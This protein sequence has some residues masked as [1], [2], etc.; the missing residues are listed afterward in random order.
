MA[1]DSKKRSEQLDELMREMKSRRPTD[2]EAPFGVQLAKDEYK[3]IGDKGFARTTIDE[4]EIAE[5][6]AKKKLNDLMSTLELNIDK[7]AK[8][9]RVNDGPPSW[10]DSDGDKSSARA[11]KKAHAASAPKHAETS[12]AKHDVKP[13]HSSGDVRPQVQSGDGRGKVNVHTEKTAK[14][15]EK[16]NN[17]PHAAIEYVELKKA[18]SARSNSAG[19]IETDPFADSFAETFGTFQ[20][21]VTPT[22]TANKQHPTQS[23]KMAKSETDYPTGIVTEERVPDVAGCEST[24]QRPEQTQGMSREVELSDTEELD[25]NRRSI[26]QTLQM[27]KRMSEQDDDPINKDMLAPSIERGVT[28]DFEPPGETEQQARNDDMGAPFAD[29]PDISR[30]YAAKHPLFSETGSIEKVIPDEKKRARQNAETAQTRVLPNSFGSLDSSAKKAEKKGVLN[31]RENVDDNFREFFGDTVIIDREALGE[32]AGRQRKIKDFVLSDGK[33]GVG[34]PVFEDED[35][36]PGEVDYRTDEDTEL[37]LKELL[38]ARARLTLRVAVTGVFAALLCMLGA[39]AEFRLLPTALAAPTVF[40]LFNLILLTGC[41]LCNVKEI[42]IGIT[43]LVTLKAAGTELVSFGVIASLVEGAVLLATFKGDYV[44]G[45]SAFV[46]GTALFACA[47]GELLDARR[48][49]DCFRTVSDNYEKYACSVLGDAAFTRSITRE[50]EVENPTVLLKR[51]TGFTDNFLQ[52]S[53]SRP[54]NEKSVSVTAFVLLIISLC[55]GGIGF[56]FGGNI[57]SG[58]RY[59]AVA[60]VFCAPFI[61]TLCVK[62]PI[63]SMQKYLSKY[64]AVVPGYS[65]AA[66]V[67]VAN[68]VVLEGRELFPKGNVMLHGIKTFERER[69]D[70]AIL[71]AASVLIQSCDT[72]SHVFMNVIQGK[73]EMLYHVDSV[74]YEGRRGFSFWIDKTRLLLGTRELMSAHE[75]EVPSRDYENRYS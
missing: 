59:A 70:K 11:P 13:S 20:P 7:Q 14:E 46:A 36:E 67:C 53:Y 32:K 45:P 31:V 21:S 57:E 71:Y 2:A 49:L 8:S 26:I 55:I 38:T 5:K 64:S 52:H 72:M 44:V 75:I 25:F 43:K 19:I 1:D 27:D 74:E 3:M 28:Y 22:Y 34:G 30:D 54:G 41:V 24:M 37:V 47:L 68:C 51:K 9:Q 33:S 56:Y 17:E 35:L 61:S 73:T 69:I 40:Y 48:V 50:L 4:N 58:A 65:A 16:R 12:S 63:V 10:S 6:N 66:E 39:M 15:Q 18:E 60:A 23:E 29:E 62:L 42:F